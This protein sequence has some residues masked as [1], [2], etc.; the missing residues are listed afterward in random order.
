MTE[1]LLDDRVEE[2]IILD[3][4][5][6]EMSLRKLLERTEK[7]YSKIKVFYSSENL[8]IAKGRKFLFDI[9][10]GD[11]ILSFDSDIVILNANGLL[12]I[13]L[14]SF[15]NP[16]IWLIGGGGGNHPYFPALF[17]GYINNLKESKNPNELTFVEEV[18]GWFHG[19]RSNML[20]K[21]GGKVYMDE[22][23]TPF[24]GEDSDFCLQIRMLGGKCAIVGAGLVGH[25]WSSCDKKDVQKTIDDMWVKFTDK[26]YPKFG[27]TFDFDFDE[28]FYKKYYGSEQ[29]FFPIKV[30]YY[31][32][33][34]PRGWLANPRFISKL[35]NTTT[36]E[37]KICFEGEEYHPRVFIDKF[38]NREEIVK[39]N[40][41]NITNNL[42]DD[43]YLIVM[44]S[45]NDKKALE[46]IKTLKDKNGQFSLALTF[47]KNRKHPKTLEYIKNNLESYAINNFVD[48]YDH[49]IAN[50]ISF[51]N[52]RNNYQ[53]SLFINSD[54][55][56][57][58][59]KGTFDYFVNSNIE[60][61]KIKTDI[62]TIDA[63]N[64][65][66]NH[67]PDLEYFE[68]A[69]FLCEHTKIN[70]ALKTLSV[71]KLLHIALMMPTRYSIHVSPRLA[72]KYSL[73]RLIGYLLLRTTPEKSLVVI[74]AEI[75]NNEDI[76]KCFNN[77]NYFK[78]ATDCDIMVMNRGD[79]KH[80]KSVQL[81]TD[82]YYITQ[83]VHDKVKNWRNAFGLCD[84]TE[85]SNVILADSDFNIEDDISEFMKIAKYSNISFL[86]EENK[87]TNHLIS[88][89]VPELGSYFRIQEEIEKA[90]KEKPEIDEK[91]T[92]DVNLR[93]GLQVHCLWQSK[94]VEDEDE[95][96][97]DYSRPD[98][99]YEPDID[100]PLV[101]DN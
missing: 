60:G 93:K 101:F 78:E 72:P 64:N 37:D 27:D 8:G 73:E 45:D 3:N 39:Y 87:I 15:K 70:K 33:G 47:D 9:C 95:I 44:H 76:E 85:Y 96:C 69:V 20:V 29:K 68:N 23:F 51:D 67:R 54:Y 18:A 31:L 66:Y 80:I 65:V 90:K 58:F 99:K 14:E 1:L 26:W 43:K 13:L 41:N 75:N 36:K 49:T 92:L 6:H 74:D 57:E 53:Y 88:F 77:N 86:E 84:L 52:I 7:M 42:K 4:G 35:F 16:D 12:T 34:I 63:I 30:D 22:R 61:N 82:Y 32:Q 48:F 94:K 17:R 55:K 100:F 59:I 28:D 21:N 40:F 19:F 98:D 5:S 50:I 56:G 38:M 11:Y 89:Q 10:K 79:K 97:F 71:Q 83:N 81:N 91:T 2:L 25:K 62:R 46:I 24:W